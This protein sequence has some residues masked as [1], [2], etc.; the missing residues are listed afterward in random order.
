MSTLED[1]KNYANKKPLL[2][3]CEELILRALAELLEEK[4]GVE[5]LRLRALLYENAICADCG[6]N[7]IIRRQKCSLVEPP[8]YYDCNCQK[9]KE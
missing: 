9:E 8:D 2:F 4:A 7:L 6:E 5:V 1:I 3:T